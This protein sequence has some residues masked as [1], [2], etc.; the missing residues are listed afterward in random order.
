MSQAGF[1][2]K[3]ICP[4]C[5]SLLM[6]CPDTE[7]LYHCSKCKI[8]FAIYRENK[9]GNFYINDLEPRKYTGGPFCSGTF[10]HC[11]RIYK[12]KVFS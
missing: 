3:Y 7:V 2:L 5:N 8:S 6:M 4:G 1:E 9:E 10:E 11:C 12:L